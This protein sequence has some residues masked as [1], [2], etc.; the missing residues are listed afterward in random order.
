MG[1]KKGVDTVHI[2]GEDHTQETQY[3]T[4]HEEKGDGKPALQDHLHP[5]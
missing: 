3:C 2:A 4:A 1:G 5:A